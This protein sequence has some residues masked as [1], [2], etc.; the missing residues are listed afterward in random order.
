MTEIQTINSKQRWGF[1]CLFGLLMLLIFGRYVF[2][3]NF[4]RAVLLAVAALIVLNGDREEI[5]AM[6]LCCIP[7]YTS[8]HY[9]YVLLI[10]IVVYVLKYSADIKVNISVL[11]VFLI[12]IWELLHG[13][14]GT[15]SIPSLVAYMVPYI[16]SALM[17]CNK[18]AGSLNYPFI[19]QVLAVCTLWMCIVVLGKELYAAEFNVEAMISN[20]QRLG[21]EEEDIA[22]SGAYFNPNTL[23]YFCL[24]ASI[25]LLQMVISKRSEKSNIILCTVLLLC[26]VLTL[27]RT[28]LVCLICM[29]VLFIFAQRETVSR[30]FQ[31]IIA[32]TVI[33][34]LG[35]LILNIFLPNIVSAL[36]ERLEADDISGG[37]LGLF[38]LYH[39]RIFESPEITWFGIGV[40]GV[41]DKLRQ[42]YGYGKKVQ[43]PHNGFQEIL[44]VWGIPGMVFFL[45]FLYQIVKRAKRVLPKP[46]LIHFIPL[47]LLLI[48]VQAGQLATSNYTILMFT[49]A[50]LSL[51]YDFENSSY[52]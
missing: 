6:A 34:A 11:P 36:M 49:H 1:F 32:I 22:V 33:A 52:E 47:I 38:G 7:L 51:C 23:G 39:Q 31:V 43:V 10:C 30:K 26:G 13:F 4:P 15:F 29:I 40:Q 37:R 17:M 3:I 50:Y 41:G 27:S 18:R 42:L 20:L 24:L 48:K 12:L 25:G 5:L 14:T 21:F 9:G 19:V 44:L 28:Y 16:F 2:Q 35:I 8:L 46:K 45:M